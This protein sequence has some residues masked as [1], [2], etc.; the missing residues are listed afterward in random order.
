MTPGPGTPLFSGYRQLAIFAVVAA[1]AVVLW[2]VALLALQDELAF[3]SAR[4]LLVAGAIDLALVLPL[5]VAA[6]VIAAST[7]ERVPGGRWQEPMVGSL[8]FTLLFL[9]ASV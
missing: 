5:I 2:E 3:L 9:F 4:R 6:L 7:A 8:V 1:V